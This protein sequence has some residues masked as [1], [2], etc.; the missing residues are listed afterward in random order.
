MYESELTELRPIFDSM[1]A[2]VN[3]IHDSLKV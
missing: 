2:T 3:G 1:L